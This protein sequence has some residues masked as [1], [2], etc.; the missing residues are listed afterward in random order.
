M[1]QSFFISQKLTLKKH[2]FMETSAYW[3]CL[4][5]D[6]L[7]PL[8]RYSTL[9][10]DPCLRAELE[11]FVLQTSW[12][13]SSFRAQLDGPRGKERGDEKAH[14]HVRRPSCRRRHPKPKGRSIRQPRSTYWP[15]TPCSFSGTLLV[16]N[17]KSGQK[18]VI[19]RLLFAH[20]QL[21]AC[22]AGDCTM[23]AVRN[24]GE[25]I[26]GASWTISLH[27]PNGCSPWDRPQSCWPGAKQRWSHLPSGLI[28]H[29]VVKKLAIDFCSHCYAFFLLH[30]KIH[31]LK[32]LKQWLFIL[33][34]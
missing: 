32:T 33:I 17:L 19:E 21:V 8:Y 23:L 9:R 29:L 10:I 25:W 16:M 7:K 26:V 22:T 34:H 14:Q 12:L 6:R 24:F 4:T 15:T 1:I 3:Y 30:S 28:K 31:L 13:Y 20:S 27:F 18:S 2:V 11:K 5:A